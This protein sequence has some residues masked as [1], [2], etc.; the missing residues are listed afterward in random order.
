[1]AIASIL[2]IP[3]KS[4]IEIDHTIGSQSTQAAFR[5]KNNDFHLILLCSCFV[6]RIQ[7]HV[8]RADCAWY[9]STTVNSSNKLSIV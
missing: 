5:A 7:R 9:I 6:Y 3:S 4:A 2:Q 1:M 8:K